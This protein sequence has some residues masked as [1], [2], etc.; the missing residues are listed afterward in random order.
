M[1]NI[2][3]RSK[4]KIICDCYSLFV[5][6]KAMFSEGTFSK[7]ETLHCFFPLSGSVIV[8]RNKMLTFSIY[9]VCHK[10]QKI[11]QM[12]CCILFM[13]WRGYGFYVEES[14]GDNFWLLPP[15]GDL[16]NQVSWGTSSKVGTSWFFTYGYFLFYYFL[17]F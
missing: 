3:N 7:M 13:S 15:S 5:S 12:S 2:L 8:L 6:Q 4:N 10:K 17:W 14:I 16:Q 9:L 11:L 1:V